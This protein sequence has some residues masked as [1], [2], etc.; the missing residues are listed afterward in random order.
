MTRGRAAYIGLFA[1]CLAVYLAI[2][3]WSLPFIAGAAGG[4]TPFDLRPTGYGFAD[5]KAFLTAL[6]P[7]GLARY[8]GAQRLLD[9]LYP[10]LLALVLAIPLWLFSARLPGA[11][12]LALVALTVL[13]MLFDLL[14]N[15]RVAGML[16]AGPDRVTADMVAAASRATVIKSAATG[17]AMVVLLGLLVWRGVQRW[18]GR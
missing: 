3:L 8:A 18:R 9:L 17:A 7:E 6:S 12:R 15:Y 13:G 4:L 10:P 2:V 1:L 5:A 11:V 14:E 16:A